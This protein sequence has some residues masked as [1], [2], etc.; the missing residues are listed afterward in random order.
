MVLQEIA[1]F[2]GVDQP[3][4]N[5]SV[6]NQKFYKEDDNEEDAKSNKTVGDDLPQSTYVK[7]VV[8]MTIL[9]T[10]SSFTSYT[11]NF[12]TKAYEGNI[13]IN[14]YLDGVA[15]IIGILLA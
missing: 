11:L 14:F 12:M 15:G 7:N 8:L 13:F 5:S 9:W 6:I 3:K 10:V 1:A 2:N 4:F